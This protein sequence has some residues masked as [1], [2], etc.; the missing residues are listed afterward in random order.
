MSATLETGGPLGAT[1]RC[2]DNG[3]I[4]QD[5]FV[6][7]LEHFS[8][9]AKPSSDD[10][11][12]LV[13]DNHGSHVSLAMYDFCKEHH[14]H[15]VSL[16]HHTSHKTQPLDVSFF[17]PLKNAFYRECDLHLKVTAHE[18]IKMFELASLFNKAYVRVATMEKAV[19]GLRSTGIFPLDVDRFT[20]D[21]FAP[22]EEYRTIRTECE[23]ENGIQ[24]KIAETPVTTTSEVGGPITS[25]SATPEI[26]YRISQHLRVPK[27]KVH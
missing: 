9:Y 15:V 17:G 16:P 21:D 10:P 2:S 23:L 19:A 7:W 13:C 12:L 3:W 25:T 18:K 4:N 20:A 8:K 6:D 1:Y 14:I 27:Y 5:L 26:Q 22:A 11:V 24:T